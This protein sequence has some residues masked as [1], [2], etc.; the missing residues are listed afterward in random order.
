MNRSAWR[1]RLRDAAAA[2]H[3]ADVRQQDADVG[4][5]GMRADCIR[6]RTTKFLVQVSALRPLICAR[7]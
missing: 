2:D 5:E 6:G 1:G 4:A 7:P 3:L